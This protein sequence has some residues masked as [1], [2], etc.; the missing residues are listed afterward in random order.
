MVFAN[1]CDQPRFSGKLVQGRFQ[2]YAVIVI[3]I[4]QNQYPVIVW[5]P[6][7]VSA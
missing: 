5:K 2:R 1:F 3:P 4:Y 6:F 7:R